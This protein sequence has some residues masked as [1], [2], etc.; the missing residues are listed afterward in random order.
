MNQIRLITGTTVE[1][2]ETSIIATQPGSS[3][4]PIGEIVEY[5]DGRRGFAIHL[6][7]QVDEHHHPRPVNLTAGMLRAIA[8]L[9]DH[10]D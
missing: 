4:I 2:Y 9:M 3:P 1:L 8:A 10:M 5:E 7:E 6:P